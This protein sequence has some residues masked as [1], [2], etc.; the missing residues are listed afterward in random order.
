MPDTIDRPTR[1]LVVDDNRDA[2]MMLAHLL[3]AFGYEVRA[4]FDGDAALAEAEQ[5]APDA[6]VLDIA[7]PGMDGYELARRLRRRG[8]GRPVLATVTGFGDLAHLDR[9][10]DVGF[11]LH[12]QKPANATEVAEQ[13]RACVRR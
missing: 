10:S 7:M 5:F 11:D 9:A 13:I 4:C 2:A 1:V 8:G 3:S 12:F 6:Y